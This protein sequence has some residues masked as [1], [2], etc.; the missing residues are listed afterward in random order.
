MLRVEIWVAGR[1]IDMNEPHGS[2]DFKFNASETKTVT[3]L[4]SDP[5]TTT[6][7][8]E[9]TTT[10][11]ETSVSVEDTTTTVEE[12]PVTVEE[13]T[14]TVEET[15]SSVSAREQMA[16]TISVQETPC[17]VTFTAATRTVTLCE[18][19][20]RIVAAAFSADGE[21]NETFEASGDSF[22][23]PA[24]ILNDNGARFLR[25][26]V[27]QKMSGLDVATFRGEGIL[28]IA[29]SGADSSGT[30]YVSPT[31][32]EALNNSGGDMTI[33]AEITE[34]GLFDINTT[35]FDPYWFVDHKQ[36]EDFAFVTL[37]GEKYTEF[38][39]VKPPAPWDSGQ[40]LAWRVY[41]TD[42]FGIP[43]LVASGR[44]ALGGS[45]EV[46]IKD[47]RFT[48]ATQRVQLLTTDG[49]S[50]EGDPCG[51]VDPYLIT[52]PNT[53]AKTNMVTLMVSTDCASADSI[54]GLVV[55]NSNEEIPTFSQFKSTR[56]TSKLSVTLFLSDAQY[57]IQWGDYTL[58]GEHEY[59]VN[60]GGTGGDCTQ[61]RLDVAP[62]GK[63]AV[64]SNC[65]PGAHRMRIF[66]DPYA[67]SEDDDIRLPF[68]NNV[69]DLTAVE[70]TGYV[71]IELNIDDIYEPDFLVCLNGCDAASKSNIDAT[72]SLD[73]SHFSTDG[74]IDISAGCTNNATPQ[75]SGWEKLPGSWAW[76]DLFMPSGNGSYLW[77]AWM[78]LDEG[79]Q[80]T[81]QRS[82]P[83]TGNGIAIT[84]CASSYYKDGNYEDTE[85]LGVD[86]F[87]IDGP[88]PN[89][90]SNDQFADAPEIEAGVGKVQFSTVSATN[91]QGEAGSDFNQSSDPGQFNS[92]WFK[93]V[94]NADWVAKFRLV[95]YTFSAV[96][97]AWRV[98]SDGHAVLQ[99]ESEV[100]PADRYWYTDSERE[101]WETLSFSVRDGQT[102]Y[103]Q[104][105][106]QNFD[107]SVGTGTIVVNDGEGSTVKVAAG[108]EPFV[109]NQELAKSVPS[110]TVPA[111]TTT[112][113]VV[114]TT[115]TEVAAS[116]VT[117]V[118][119]NEQRYQ[120]AREIGSQ[121]E[122]VVVLAPT[123]DAPA[124]IEAREDARTVQIPVADL[125]G[126][127]SVA[128]A[129][130]DSARSLTLRA[131]GQRPI[132]VRP[133]DKFV[134]VPVG[135]KTTDLQIKATTTDG[136]TV[137]TPLTIKKT[138]P[139]LVTISGADGSS[140]SSTG[141]YAGIAAAVLLLLLAFFLVKR[142]KEGEETA[143]QA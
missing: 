51:Q 18:S 125:Y 30:I 71:W 95:D 80:S 3:Y 27:A 107:Q 140:S 50:P 44:L 112:T 39:K 90:P 98:D 96:M 141:L 93:Y 92:V 134:T 29:D 54:L 120:T 19:F 24:K 62:D 77:E 82:M 143:E 57:D 88:M 36:E 118:S 74:T 137:V 109:S 89:R 69:I 4:V 79:K 11:E 113:T 121:N 81:E 106:N 49:S 64:L 116:P 124:T 47:P 17:N 132:K 104:I 35:W 59:V 110:T 123:K 8:D 126:T 15:S 10:L 53:P 142:R 114:T 45:S 58:V 61:P 101:R 63:S 85:T 103:L 31:G 65:D 99:D 128:S 34:A 108:T 1:N 139:P 41:F 55:W 12:T 105:L 13:T 97:R 83:R 7:V 6:A 9:T 42:G 75:G 52:T 43:R 94:A 2:A 68:R 66:A 122:Q 102:Y 28:D 138:A 60:G 56:Y 40:T 119:P 23:I 130:V 78:H 127:V 20:D 16:A 48:L 129:N 111:T 70:W 73:V 67:N 22:E 135:T 5:T 136:K 72:A 131:P 37:N 133:G 46:D 117:T 87:S 38:E 25:I 86:K 100:W 76:V 26:A 33:T 32:T 91:E 115:S 84:G 14:T 21:F